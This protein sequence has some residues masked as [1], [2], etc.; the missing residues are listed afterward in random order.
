MA[1]SAPSFHLRAPSFPSFFISVALI[2]DLISLSVLPVSYLLP[3]LL[4]S[5]FSS[6]DTRGES[7]PVGSHRHVF[8]P[9]F[10]LPIPR[11]P[12]RL[13]PV[14]PPFPSFPASISCLPKNSPKNLSVFPKTYLSSLKNG[15][16]TGFPK[17]CP[18]PKNLMIFPKTSPDFTFWGVFKGRR[19]GLE[20]LLQQF[21]LCFPSS[22]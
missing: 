20:G 15:L 1:K 21:P 3:R 16:F 13:I 19:G 12:A 2:S 18:F 14:S 17:T 9:Y 7:G 4:S 8:I 5:P 11:F 10:D 22:V 6:T